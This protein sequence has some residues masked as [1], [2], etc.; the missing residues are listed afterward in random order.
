MT[1]E[2][3]LWIGGVF[4]GVAVLCG[5]VAALWLERTAPERKRLLAVAAP[6]GPGFVLEQRQLTESADPTLQKLSKALPRSPQDMSRLRR[7]LASAGIYDLR[8]AVIYS[9]AE[10]TLPLLMAGVVFLL[11]GLGSGWVL[12]LLAAV[13]GYL[14]PGLWLQRRITLRKKS[15]QNGLP[16]ALDLLIICMESGSSM[17][18]AIAKA[19][20][21]LGISHPAVAYELRL[22][23]TEIRAG[24]PRMEAMKNFA[25][26]TGVDDVRSLVAML[27]QTDRFGTSVSQALRIHASNARTKR[28][29]LAEERAG[30]IGV[31]LVF[32]LAL[33]IFPGVYV[34]CLGP[35]VVAVYRTLM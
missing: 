31:K 15:I 35:A 9:L 24:K 22:I 32:P 6:A 21:E 17:D 18:Q 26:R 27:V 4:I 13:V 11:M 20:E 16:D 12:M 5:A 29:Q 19:S 8:A 34:V 28:R 3:V 23:T 7:Q 33:C 10:I 30:K 2:L 25:K 14:A 1:P